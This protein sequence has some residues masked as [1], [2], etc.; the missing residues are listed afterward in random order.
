MTATISW[1]IVNLERQL[2]D[3]YVF[4]A[5]YTVNAEDGDDSASSYGS[6][7]LERPDSLIPFS[8]LTE[9]VVVSWVKDKLGAEQVAAIEAGLQN[10][11]DK[12]RTPTTETGV[13][14]A[15]TLDL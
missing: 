5:H 7:G 2:A 13:P 10:Q 8:Q 4:T 6:V 9:K 1:A 3:G 14:W 11:I 12:K 15:T